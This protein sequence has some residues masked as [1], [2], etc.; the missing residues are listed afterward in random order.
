[1]FRGDV[2]A[3][4]ELPRLPGSLR[5]ATDIFERSAFAQAS[6][7]TDVVEHYVHFYRTEQA[8]YDTAVTDWERERYFERI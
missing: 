7:G 4:S 6:L 1:M 5:D 8:A 3:A 2:Y